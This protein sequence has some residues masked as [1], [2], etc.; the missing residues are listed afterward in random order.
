MLTIDAHLSTFDKCLINMCV[1]SI[2]AQSLQEYARARAREH[3]VIGKRRKPLTHDE[4]RQ[5]ASS[6]KV[7]LRTMLRLYQELLRTASVAECEVLRRAI[8]RTQAAR[9]RAETICVRQ[10]GHDLADTLF[11]GEGWVYLA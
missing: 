3:A 7:T 5:F 4:W 8:K 9:V 2:D 1:L 11:Y 10:H 6:F